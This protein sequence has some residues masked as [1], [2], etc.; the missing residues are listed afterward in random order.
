MKRIRQL[1]IVAMMVVG[2]GCTSNVIAPQIEEAEIGFNAVTSHASKAIL[3]AGALPTNTDFKVWGFYS[4]NGLF[5]E[6]STAPASNFMAGVHIEWTSG[7][8][9]SKMPVWRNRVKYYF[10]PVS[11]KVGFYALHPY[12]IGS[13]VL[14]YNEGVRVTDYELREATKYVDLMYTY[15]EGENRATALPLNFKHALS[16]IEIAVKLKENYPDVGFEIL[17][18][19]FVNIDSKATFTYSRIEDS[20][21]WS[22]ENDSHTSSLYYSTDRRSVLPQVAIYSAAMGMIPQTL[23]TVDGQRTELHIE[24]RISQADGTIMNGTIVKDLSSIQTKWIMGTK[25]LYTLNFSLREITFNPTVTEWAEL[26][27]SEITIP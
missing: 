23:S 2:V 9:V 26:T 4:P 21:E 1:L 13:S 16:Q 19:E 24:Y 10:W 8:D 27:L 3:G 6:F 7:A 17:S 18:A 5:T 14:G 20:G 15:A 11:G 12:D 22:G 25:Y